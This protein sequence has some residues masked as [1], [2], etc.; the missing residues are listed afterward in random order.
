MVT[1]HAQ[2]SRMVASPPLAAQRPTMHR[3]MKMRHT[4]CTSIIWAGQDRH[5]PAPIV[6]LC[7]HNSHGEVHVSV[8]YLR[9]AAIAALLLCIQL[10]PWP[11]FMALAALLGLG[12]AA[13]R[14]SW[15]QESLR[16]SAI[17]D[18]RGSGVSQDE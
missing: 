13:M 18:T 1:L 7:L 6:L 4:S 3:A 17:L 9:H 11:L 16:G 14:H 2:T 12:L 15:A 10:R 5:G 8:A